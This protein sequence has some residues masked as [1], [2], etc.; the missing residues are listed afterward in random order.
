MAFAIISDIHANL[1]AF[2]AVLKDIRKR[3]INSIYSCGDI[4]GYGASPNECIELLMKNKIKSVLG[5]HDYEIFGVNKGLFSYSEKLIYGDSVVD[6]REWTKEKL[7]KKNTA[8]LS[9]LVCTL[10]LDDMLIVHG[11][12]SNPLNERIDD[13]YLSLIPW[14]V[15]VLFMGHTHKPFVK[16]VNGK[17]AVNPGS[18]GQP[19]DH[20][21]TASYC[22]FEGN[23]AEIVRVEYD[24]KNAAKKIREAG[25][26]EV[27]ASRLFS[28][29]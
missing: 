3:R 6:V 7:T 17:L 18:V 27:Y 14:D 21:K 28:G 11:S 25:F 10:K 22:I 20:D 13:I 29:I 4:V 16:P 2:V 19:R 26:P 1:E 9:S 15:R 24:I 12:P 23:D 8:Y 5:N